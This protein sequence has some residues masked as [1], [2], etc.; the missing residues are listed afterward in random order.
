MRRVPNVPFSIRT[1]VGFFKQDPA[2]LANQNRSAEFGVLLEV[3][4]RG[5][6]APGE[7]ILR[8]KAGAIPSQ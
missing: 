3:L 4:Y 1:P 6:G 2:I 7:G 5:F 8:E